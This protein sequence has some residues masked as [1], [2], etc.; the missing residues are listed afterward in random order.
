MVFYPPKKNFMSGT[1]SDSNINNVEKKLYINQQLFFKQT[2]SVLIFMETASMIK[3]K[4]VQFLIRFKIN[5]MKTLLT[6]YIEQLA[7]KRK[8]FEELAIISLIVR[9]DYRYIVLNKRQ[10]YHLQI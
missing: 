8:S 10:L 6:T 5:K 9:F 1:L 3:E 7:I 4:Q 2:D